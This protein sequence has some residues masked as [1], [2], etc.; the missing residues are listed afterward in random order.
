MPNQIKTQETSSQKFYLSR[1]I[2]R[3]YAISASIL[4][5]F[6]G[7][8]A[9]LPFEKISK[10]SPIIIYLVWGAGTWFLLKFNREG[11][12][13][14]ET[15]DDYM[16]VI[17]AFP[18]GGKIR[19]LFHMVKVFRNKLS[20]SKIPYRN[21]EAIVESTDFW[22][23]GEVI[24][25]G[26]DDKGNPFQFPCGI[27]LIDKK[28][29]LPRLIEVLQSKD[30]PNVL[31]YPPHPKPLAENES[32]SPSQKKTIDA[33]KTYMTNKEVTEV[34]DNTDDRVKSVD[35]FVK[36]QNMTGSSF[37]IISS[38][39]EIAT[40]QHYHIVGQGNIDSPAMWRR[41]LVYMT[42]KAMAETEL[43]EIEI[44]SQRAGYNT[45]EKLEAIKDFQLHAKVSK[46]E[47]LQIIK[48][49]S[50]VNSYNELY[51]TKSFLGKKGFELPNETFQNLIEN[52]HKEIAEIIIKKEV[53]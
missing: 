34:M 3:G 39:K 38:N 1:S 46:T 35:Y 41:G 37:K 8:I 6:F 9:H 13:A 16:T 28:K 26:R 31:G 23:Q 2:I 32:L 21:I 14:V 15:F 11:R 49:H 40:L 50:G 52:N 43:E 36:Q 33:L 45:D 4:L 22:T 30:I 17:G 25:I 5:L 18:Y 48:K 10:F 53:L 12:V 24:I 42:I 20:R 44:I 19:Q 27:S 51:K 47:L 7:P 29:D